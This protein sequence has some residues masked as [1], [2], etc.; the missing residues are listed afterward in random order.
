MTAGLR[1]STDRTK[2]S[3]PFTFGIPLISR[4]GARNWALVEALLGLTLA[5][6]FAQ[7]DQDFRIVLAGHDRPR[8]LPDD[9]RVTFLEAD[10]PADSPRA[11]NLDS[12]R[13]KHAINAH[14]L[15]R[16]GG[17]LMFLDADDWVDVGMVAV[18]RSRIGLRHVGGLVAEGYATDLRT[19]RAAPLP[20]ARVFDRAFHRICGSSTVL[21][22]RP[23]EDHPLRRDPHADFHEHYRWPEI[24]AAHGVELAQLPV[25][26]NYLVGTSENH[27]E[28]HGPF[29]DWRRAFTEAVN[30]EG[31]AIGGASAARFGL[32]LAAIRA[33]SDR[34]FPQSD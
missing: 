4:R 21:C 25:I 11:D 8:S 30:R 10:W 6:V 12:G 32:G 29:A 16:G 28:V 13:K 22:L 9:P 7:T 5:S 17:L 24:A 1:V 31:E 20:H 15:A 18:S 26:G 33:V 19:L 2:A 14:V 3:A 27:S 23:E 34:F